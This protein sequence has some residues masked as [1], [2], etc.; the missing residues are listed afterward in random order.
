VT[1]VRPY[2][3]FSRLD[4]LLFVSSSSS[5]VLMRLSGPCSRPTAS[6]KVW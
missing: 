4:P 2:S 5:V 6:Q 3:W 1:S